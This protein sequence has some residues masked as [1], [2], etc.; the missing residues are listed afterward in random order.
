MCRPAGLGKA[1]GSWVS[2]FRPGQRVRHSRLSS[3]AAGTSQV[4][5]LGYGRPGLTCRVALAEA[6]PSGRGEHGGALCGSVV[7]NKGGRPSLLGTGRNL[8]RAG[9]AVG[10]GGRGGGDRARLVAAWHQAVEEVIV[11]RTH[12][13]DVTVAWT[14]NR[15][16]G[17]S[18]YREY[19]RDHEVTVSGDGDGEGAGDA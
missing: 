13:Y 1:P 17:P 11:I 14:G 18:G 9:P 8:V 7:P 12:S 4:D 5:R 2:S 19:D 16:S 15:G 6:G 10:S 3:A